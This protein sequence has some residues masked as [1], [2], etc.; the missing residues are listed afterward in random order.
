MWS[1]LLS[2]ADRLIG[3]LQQEEYANGQSFWDRTL[4]YVA[5]DFGRTKARPANAPDFGSGHD[6]NNGSL[7]V[8]P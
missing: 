8:S 2:V 3:L 7:I 5:T 1:R 4:L 6:L